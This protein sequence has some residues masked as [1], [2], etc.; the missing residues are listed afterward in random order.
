M[1]NEINKILFYFN[2]PMIT[3]SIAVSLN[4]NVLCL[5]YSQYYKHILSTYLKP[6]KRKTSVNNSL[7]V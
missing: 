6:F 2:F 1:F 3:L 4:E 5:H 7:F